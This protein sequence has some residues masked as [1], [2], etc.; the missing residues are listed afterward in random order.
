MDNTGRGLRVDVLRPSHDDSTLGGVSA[1]ANELTVVGVL[2]RTEDRDATEI[3]PLP[4]RSRVHP[5]TD[6]APA[7]VL[8]KRRVN[9]LAGVI[10]HLAP[11]EQV[12]AGRHGAMGGN[13]AATTDS[14]FS[15]LTG[16]LYGAVAVHDRF[17]GPRS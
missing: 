9:G 12:Q 13:Y 6:R 7:V 8:V 17:E 2:D 11:L 3:T 16:G 10:L 5:V 14:R 4:A 1:Q 15:L